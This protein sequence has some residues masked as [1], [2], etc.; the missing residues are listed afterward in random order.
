MEEATVG[1]W[2]A[3][4]G[5]AV[6]PLAPVVE[7]ITDKV[8]YDIEA[9]DDPAGSILLVCCAPEKAVLPVDSVIAIVGRAGE[10]PGTLPDW[11]AENADLAAKHQAQL[12]A[13]SG[14][15]TPPAV[16]AADAAPGPAAPAGI[17]RATPAAR[18]AARAAGVTLEDVALSAAG[19]TITEADVEA[20]V[21]GLQQP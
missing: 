2:H 6:A 1:H 10:S 7:I 8:S 4:E 12:Q 18:R 14:Q 17:I 9:P 20:F 21:R 3:A 5:A 16:G 13:G 11:R 15:A 19:S